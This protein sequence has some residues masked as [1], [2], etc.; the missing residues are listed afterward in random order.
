M[1]IERGPRQKTTS[2]FVIFLLSMLGFEFAQAQQEVECAKI[3]ITSAQSCQKM[4][5]R[6]DLSACTGVK[7]LSSSEVR[8]RNDFYADLEAQTTNGKVRASLT[9]SVDGIWAPGTLLVEKLENQ[10]AFSLDDRSHQFKVSGQFRTRLENQYKTDFTTNRSPIYLRLRPR[11]EW[12]PDDKTHVVFEPQGSKAYGEEY[13]YGNSTASNTRTETSGASY[14][15]PLTLHQAYGEYKPFEGFM[16]RVGRM[17]L[18]Y[19]DELLIGKGDWGN[20]GNSFD[21]GLI[22]YKWLS[23]W[24]HFFATKIQD[25][26]ISTNGSG[27]EDFNGLYASWSFGDM[28][29]ALDLYILHKQD[30][31]DLDS[32]GNSIA[33]AVRQTWAYG[34]RVA[35][36]P[37]PWDYRAEFTREN[38]GYDGYQ[39]NAE[40]GYRFSVDMNPRV[41]LEYFFHDENYHPLYP[42]N[43]RWV[44]RSDILGM[45]NITGEALHLELLPIADVQVGVDYFR[46][47]RVS[48]NSPAYKTNAINTLGLV[49]A[50][51]A[52]DLGTELDLNFKVRAT[53]VTSFSGG[54]ALFFPGAYFKDQFGDQ[55]Y[56]HYLQMEIVF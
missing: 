27:N 24:A 5:A 9:K 23:G 3:I 37:K 44:G 49:A 30:T 22:E 35:S 1:Y 56:Q 13:Y 18:S 47:R 46:L 26:S 4:K 11:L 20:V 48:T 33:S 10:T 12:Q 53:E 36:Q 31:T 29:R 7:L 51:E 8:C 2:L 54:T 34:I 39:L 32:N 6:I 14:D 45:R 42:T 15:T 28:L 55:P 43:R 41:S 38:T 19:G 52:K 21:G 25:Q 17:T 50:S 40:S 16:T